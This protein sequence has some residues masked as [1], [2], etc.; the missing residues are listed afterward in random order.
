MPLPDFFIVGHQ[1][2]GTTALH[3]MLRPHPQI[4]LPERKEPLY[5]VP[6]IVRNPIA[7]EE[8]EALF[9]AATPGQHIG[10]A[11]PVYLWSHT[12]PGR[13]AGDVPDAKIIAILREPADFLRTLHLQFLR[14]GIETE[15]DFRKAIELDHERAAGQKIPRNSPRPE[16]LP[17]AEHLR[18]MDQLERYRALFSPERVLVLIYEEYRADNEA[19]LQRILDFLEVERVE[20]PSLEANTRAN[21][22]RS[23]L[24]KDL[25]RSLYLGRGLPGK[26]K[27]AIK[28][29]TT[30]E[31]RRRLFKAQTQAQR[32]EVAPP[33]EEY[34][35]TLRH[36][37]KDDVAV[38]SDYLGRDLVELWGYS[39]L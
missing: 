22:V 29:V 5:Y 13:I 14:V 21:S 3:R 10:E 23:P 25:T 30:P 39:D 2:C 6:D 8:Y 15:K 32:R 33:S 20:L 4:F 11:T 34:M 38:L 18:Y 7:R 9:E 35:T 17:Y 16:F 1:K 24:L 36:R 12:A 27:P 37:Y 28:A 31:M 19:T 26:L